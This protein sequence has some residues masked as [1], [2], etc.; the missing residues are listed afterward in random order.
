MLFY[1]EHK[2][3]AELRCKTMSEEEQKEYAQLNARIKAHQDAKDAG[4]RRRMASLKPGEKYPPGGFMG[5]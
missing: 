4:F 1:E 5:E 2:R 3:M